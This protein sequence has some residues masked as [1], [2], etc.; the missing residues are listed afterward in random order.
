MPKRKLP[1]SFNYIAV[2]TACQYEPVNLPTNPDEVGWAHVES[3]DRFL[4]NQ[5]DSSDIPQIKLVS[6]LG[7]LLEQ[8]T[9]RKIFFEHQETESRDLFR[10]LAFAD[11]LVQEKIIR[12]VTRRENPT[13][14]P[15]LVEFTVNVEPQG[16]TPTDGV[17]D[18]GT[19]H[20]ASLSYVRALWKTLGEGAER[21]A[22]T[23]YLRRDFL[24]DTFAEL[25]EKRAINPNR[26]SAFSEEEKQK[27][28]LRVVTELSKFA[29]AEMKHIGTG[30]ITL[31]PAQLMYYNYTLLGG[32][33]FLRQPISTGAAAHFVWEEAL[34]SGLCEAIERDAYMIAY[35][36]KLP[37]TR[38]NIDK[39]RQPD[40]ARLVESFQRY[41]IRLEILDMT[42]DIKIPSIIALGIDEQSDR[43]PAVGIGAKVDTDPLWAIRGAIEELWHTF[44]HTRLTCEQNPSLVFRPWRNDQVIRATD[45][46]LFWA[47]PEMRKHV[48]FFLQ[49]P[50]RPYRGPHEFAERRPV[51]QLEQ[52]V[53]A[54]ERAGLSD[55]Y[56]RDLTIPALGT[57]GYRVVYTLVPELT[58]MYL[59]EFMHATGGIRLH[60]VPQ[61]LGYKNP[62]QLNQ[63]P[64]PFA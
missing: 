41:G 30:Q 10:V 50:K 14:F 59:N 44:S 6:R 2:D 22:Q 40:V 43:G 19:G 61:K 17:P 56:Y 7:R 53:S 46:M 55:I 16:N 31:V 62:R 38:I 51:Q 25:G 63:V 24:V 54:L 39:I 4:A 48:Q 15:Q 64:H 20:G 45:H 29:W 27:D 32:E 33:S 42:T 3:L 26:L 58:H 12:G 21:Y 11:Y 23:R 18:P 47:R 13:D 60:T 28:S 34:Y 35:M 52:T 9:K 49:K 37:L 1:P 36:N 8:W 5:V 57:V